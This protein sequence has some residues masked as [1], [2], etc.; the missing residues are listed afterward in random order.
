MSFL[1]KKISSSFK[2]C[3]TADGSI[4]HNLSKIKTVKETSGNSGSSHNRL[5]HLDRD[6][7]HDHRRT[8]GIDKGGEGL[9][10]T[11]KK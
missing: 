6:F 7:V 10:K 2:C 1:V 4:D 9:Q 8:Q 11:F 3:K 5:Y